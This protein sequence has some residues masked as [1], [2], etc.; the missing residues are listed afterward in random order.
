[1]LICWMFTVWLSMRTLW[2]NLFGFEPWIY[3]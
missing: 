1:L 2:A 3:T